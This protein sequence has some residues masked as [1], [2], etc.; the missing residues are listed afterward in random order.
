MKIAYITNGFSSNL[1]SSY[2]LFRRLTLAG[3]EVTY[4]S[5]ENVGQRITDNGFPFT[6]LG[7]QDRLLKSF[8][9]FTPAFPLTSRWISDRRQK[10]KL[11]SQMLASEELLSELERLRV[12]VLVIDMELHFAII[13]C[14]KLG[15]PIILVICWYSIYRDDRL[16]PL[17]TTLVPPVTHHQEVLIQAA[18]NREIRAKRKK[19]IRQKIR[20]S[21]RDFFS[22]APVPVDTLDTA[23]LSRVAR[24]HGLKLDSLVDYGHW[25]RPMVFK[26]LPVMAYNIYEMDFPH[27]R[28]ADLHYVGPMICERRVDPAPDKK[29]EKIWE[30][31]R[32]ICQQERTSRPLVYC[33]LGTFWSADTAFL[34]K[35]IDIFNKRTD[36][37]LVIGLGGKLTANEFSSIPDNVTVLQWAP[38]LQIL[39]LASCA[40]THGGITTINECVH[41]GV[42]MLVYSTAH[43]DQNGCAARVAWHGLGIMGDRMNDDSTRMAAQIESLITRP[44]YK[45][46]LGIMKRHF[47]RYERDNTAVKIIEHAGLMGRHHE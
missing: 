22:P 40:I 8:D 10:R 19:R 44:E 46:Q 20:Y 21:L 16:P 1:N 4:L 33:S 31:V 39:E 32:R 9:S 41:Y 7:D 26:Q 2:E 14:L 18:W 43:G 27:D 24:Y 11:Q 25:L 29:S 6:R 12:D 28:H 5:V 45:A 23:Q 36:W 38:Q 47:E 34:E 17:H 42:P 3:H 30:G 37:R 35:V 13:V 15:L